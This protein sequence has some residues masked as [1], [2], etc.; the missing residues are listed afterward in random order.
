MP[1]QLEHFTSPEDPEV[2]MNQVTEIIRKKFDNLLYQIDSKPTGRW[3]PENFTWAD[4]VNSAIIDTLIDIPEHKALF[5]DNGKEKSFDIYIPSV[6][7]HP[8]S[9]E[10]AL[11][12]IELIKRS[13]KEIKIFTGNID[14]SVYVSSLV[15]PVIFQW[16]SSDSSRTISFI[17]ESSKKY[18]H[19]KFYSLLSDLAS[20]GFEKVMEQIDVRY[21]DEKLCPKCGFYIA[22]FDDAGIKIKNL[23]GNRVVCNFYAP[24][25]VAEI[26][27]LFKKVYV[28]DNLSHKTPKSHCCTTALFPPKKALRKN[29]EIQSDQSPAREISDIINSVFTSQKASGSV[30]DFGARISKPEAL[31]T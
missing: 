4:N 17:C 23:D 27:S 14:D 6:D 12:T 26:L 5:T 20:D 2:S 24:D 19:S 7:K 8:Y 3:N 16:L 18:E 15:Y 30:L 22:I 9:I 29:T 28:S 25:L 1:E 13:K 10:M 11:T 21:L 31:G